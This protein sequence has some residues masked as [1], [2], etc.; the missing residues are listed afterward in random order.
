MKLNCLNTIFL[1]FFVFSL[2]AQYQWN[3]TPLSNMPMR[4]SNNAVA[5]FN[6][7]TGQ[8]YLYSFGGI[9]ST[10]SSA[11]IHQR[12]FELNFLSNS[13]SEKQAL[14]DTLGKIAMGAS[15][16][17]GKIFVIG[18]YHVLPNGNEIS[19]DKVH[20]FNPNLGVFE[21]DAASIPV[22]IDDHVQC[23]Y[24]DSL[25]FVVTGWSQTTNKPDV[26]IFNPTLNQWTTGT[27]L[28]NNNNFKAF[29]ASGYIVG[30]TLYYFGGVTT[31]LSF[32]ARDYM[33]K[34]FIN[35]NDPTDIVWSTMSP[36]PGGA[37]YR[38]ACGASGETVFWV[39]GSSVGYNFDGMAYNGSGG[40]EPE[41][42][43]LH[44]NSPSNNYQNNSNEPYAVMD[45]RGIGELGSGRWLIC[46][47]MDSNQVVSNR[48]FLLENSSLSVV[49]LENIPDFSIEYL[50]EKVVV[51]STIPVDIRLFTTDGRMVKKVQNNMFFEMN[52][53]D[54]KSGV[55]IVSSDRY[56]QRIILF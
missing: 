49:A 16:V 18:G 55:Y 20:V 4:T 30:D 33:R 6:S 22:P 15:F 26:Q 35:P 50:V 41:S 53:E 40:V 7:V 10:K 21:N 45:L 8:S 11:G 28:P 2:E 5:S 43:I 19:S 31:G 23:V 54:F 25:I 17:K 13:W 14:P 48:S 39:G 12:V 9:D 34:G 37:G 42:R 29:G 3:W 27:S 47:G 56:S 36:A 24:K 1:F 52:R 38:M 44:L 46:G 51:K 32:V